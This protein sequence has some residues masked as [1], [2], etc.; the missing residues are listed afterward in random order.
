MYKVKI[1]EL[2]K[3]KKHLIKVEKHLAAPK[4]NSLKAEENLRKENAKLIKTL[5]ENYYI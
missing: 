4:G 5:E 3:I 2:E 1:D